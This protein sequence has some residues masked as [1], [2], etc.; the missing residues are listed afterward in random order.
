MAGK[1]SILIPA[2]KGEAQ[3]GT[4]HAVPSPAKQ[5]TTR[6]RDSPGN[7]RKAQLSGSKRPTTIASAR[8]VTYSSEHERK[9]DGYT[10]VK[11]A[12][13]PQV[14]PDAIAVSSGTF[15]VLRV[16]DEDDDQTNHTTETMPTTED[17]TT[18]TTTT[19]TTWYSGI[20]T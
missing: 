7:Q 19:E 17:N 3:Q 6:A 10:E 20:G 13:R 12:S 1:K 9:E 11:Q 5:S 18:T 2:A 8:R 16:E 14:T 4:Q 15:G